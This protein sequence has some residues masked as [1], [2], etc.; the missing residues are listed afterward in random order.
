MIYV[1]NCNYI[2]R[3]LKKKYLGYFLF[4]VPYLY[5]ISLKPFKIKDSLFLYREIV[6]SSR[7]FS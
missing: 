1:D 7:F 6:V 4:V 2:A 5:L 3:L